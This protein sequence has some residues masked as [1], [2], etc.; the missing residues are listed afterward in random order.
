MCLNSPSHGLALFEACLASVSRKAG[1]KLLLLFELS[2]L[3]SI[4]KCFFSI[5]YLIRSAAFKSLMSSFTPFIAI[6][7]NMIATK[8]RQAAN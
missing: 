3:L 7:S 4:F 5:F 2:K 1:A 6:H 8:G